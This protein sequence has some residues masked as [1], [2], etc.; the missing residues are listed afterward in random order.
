MLNQV[1]TDRTNALHPYKVDGS[2]KHPY[3]AEDR[4]AFGKDRRQYWKDRAKK[5]IWGILMLI[6][7]YLQ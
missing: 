4:N 3:F 7:L 5:E 6:H 2:D 1:P